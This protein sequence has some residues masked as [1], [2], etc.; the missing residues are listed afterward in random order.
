WTLLIGTLP[1]AFALSS[2]SLDPL[3]TDERQVEEVFLTAAQSLLAVVLLINLRMSLWEAGTVLVLFLAQF[4]TPHDIIS[5]DTFSY[6]YLLLAAMFLLRQ[7]LEMRPFIGGPPRGQLAR[8][9]S[10]APEPSPRPAG[11]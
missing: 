5:R 8:P 4:F 9:P 7:L 6:A 10:R 11:S 1:I 2:Q 3:P